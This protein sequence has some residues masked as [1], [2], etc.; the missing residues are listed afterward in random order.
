MSEKSS[1]SIV[2]PSVAPWWFVMFVPGYMPMT[3]TWTWSLVK[4]RPWEGSIS[5]GGHGHRFVA[6]FF[7]WCCDRKSPM[8][9]RRCLERTSHEVKWQELPS[10]EC[11]VCFGLRRKPAVCSSPVCFDCCFMLLLSLQGGGRNEAAE[12]GH[13]NDF[14]ACLSG[15][16][17]LILR[18]SKIKTISP[19]NFSGARRLCDTCARNSE[20]H[21]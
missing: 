9:E 5:D 17:F 12:K 8:S 21:I 20:L 6:A 18:E 1:S 14:C 19:P 7:C 2:L 15:S 13:W 11:I 4:L 10:I 3:N 16:T